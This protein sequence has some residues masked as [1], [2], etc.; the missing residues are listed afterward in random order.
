VD[1]NGLLFIPQVIG[2]MST[3]NHD[4]M[5]SAGENSILVYQ[6]SLTILLAESSDSK[7]GEWAKGMRI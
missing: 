7:Q 6:S 1:T 3:K 2:Y 5:I 4:R